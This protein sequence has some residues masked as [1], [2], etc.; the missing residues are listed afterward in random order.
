MADMLQPELH[1][2]L[3]KGLSDITIMLKKAIGENDIETVV[4]LTEEHENIM[5]KLK[6]AG[7]SNDPQMLDLIKEIKDEIDE[8]IVEIEKKRDETGRELKKI[9][10][11][12]KLVAAY[13]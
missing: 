7:L 10:N 11:G 13:R 9:V 4:R 12:K 8:L 2:T 3:Y 5:N 1:K 6:H